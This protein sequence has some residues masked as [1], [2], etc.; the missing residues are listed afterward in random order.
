MADI[1]SSTILSEKHCEIVMAFQYQ[2]V[3]TVMRSALTK[4]DVSTLQANANGDACTGVKILKCTWV[5]KV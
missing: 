1:T 2:Y 4:V 3:D 5:V